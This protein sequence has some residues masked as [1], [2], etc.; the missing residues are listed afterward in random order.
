MGPGDFRTP[1]SHNGG[2]GGQF[3]LDILGG[4]H[5]PTA[6]FVHVLS[7]FGPFS[8]GQQLP[9]HPRRPI[10]SPGHLAHR[11]AI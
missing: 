7:H 5:G 6:N 8:E 1:L 3:S 11:G 10:L 9:G 4:L 2:L